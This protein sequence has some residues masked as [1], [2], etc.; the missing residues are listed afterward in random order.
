MTLALTYPDTASFYIVGSGEYANKK[1]IEDN[2]DV[3][4]IFIQATG[5]AHAGFQDNID[6]DAVA[7][8]DFNNAFIVEHNN[9]LEGMYILMEL[10][11]SD[12]DE[13]WYK[14]TSVIVNRDHLLGNTIDN[15]Q[16]LLKKTS[17]L[18]GV[19]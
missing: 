13:S 9:R 12:A 3:N 6:A 7:Y 16:L 19:S 1:V 4:V 14:V 5:F 15:I 2:A 18:P 11:G 17:A 8:V 10:F